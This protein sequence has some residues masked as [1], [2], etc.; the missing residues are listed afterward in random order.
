[1]RIALDPNWQGDDATLEIQYDILGR[2]ANGDDYGGIIFRL[3]TP[4]DMSEGDRMTL[5]IG[6]GEIQ[7]P[8]GAGVMD[9]MFVAREE[10]ARE[11]VTLLRRALGDESETGAGV[12]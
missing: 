4:L 6:S 5:G 10:Q 3:H 7:F 1:M 2:D 12:S 8:V 9:F 11:L